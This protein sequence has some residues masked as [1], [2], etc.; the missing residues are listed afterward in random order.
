MSAF[1]GGGEK[2]KSIIT[3]YINSHGAD[4]PEKKI[5]PDPSVRILSQAGKFGCAGF[6]DYISLEQVKKWIKL[7]KNRE[8][9]T[10]TSTYLMLEKII[11]HFKKEFKRKFDKIQ[12]EDYITEEDK[13]EL[14]NNNTKTWHLRAIR[15]TLKVIDENNDWQIYTPIFDH[16][17]TFDDV[18]QRGQGIFIADIK[19]KP[20][21]F[22]YK[23]DDD[24]SITEI[25]LKEEFKEMH[26]LEFFLNHLILEDHV[27]PVKVIDGLDKLS[28]YSLD[29][30]WRALNSADSKNKL[31]TILGES[32]FYKINKIIEKQ[33][34]HL[35]YHSEILQ[36]DLI[37]LLKYEGFDIIN[38]IDKSC[39]AY[40][41]I[42]S[43]E[44]FAEINKDEGEASKSID[45]S[46]GGK[47][48]KKLGKGE[49]NRISSG[50]HESQ[51]NSQI[52]TLV[53]RHMF[54]N[55]WVDLRQATHQFNFPCFLTH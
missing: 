22:T 12:Q 52:Q 27:D 36:S 9:G 45:R 2:P 44:K 49:R 31:I 7:L 42:M 34:S 43:K 13:H 8:P 10:V 47:K 55:E 15:N 40:G 4:I 50:R 46:L 24:L 48:R 38:I 14:I 16:S 30:Y 28:I 32:I 17:Y 23:V 35:E 41:A 21:S 33:Y 51:N 20:E 37:E 54:Q 39:R 19:N 3:L 5:T 29:N 6:I 25:H 11:I 53:R 26:I 18:T 1:A